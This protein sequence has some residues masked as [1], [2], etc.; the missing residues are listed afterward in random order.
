MLVHALTTRLVN[1][2][3]ARGL[4]RAIPHP[5]VR[6]VAMVLCS[7]LVSR[8]AERGLAH[9]ASVARRAP[10]ISRRLRSAAV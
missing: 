4:A 6:A 7:V 2:H 9:A 3:V 8:L 1:R 5:G 10:L